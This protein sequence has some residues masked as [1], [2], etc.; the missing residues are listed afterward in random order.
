MRDD[1][2]WLSLCWHDRTF[3]RSWSSLRRRGH[4]EASSQPPPRPT[5]SLA[6]TA[7]RPASRGQN[8]YR[9]LISR[10][11]LNLQKWSPRSVFPSHLSSRKKFGALLMN[12]SMTRQSLRHQLHALVILKHG[13]LIIKVTIPSSQQDFRFHEA[14]GP[15]YRGPPLQPPVPHP[16]GGAG[17]RPLD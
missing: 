17:A 9:S 7:W 16:H 1:L 3:G 8:T 13:S 14:P 10:K 6:L 5:W 11:W 4:S 15:V 2:S 12:W